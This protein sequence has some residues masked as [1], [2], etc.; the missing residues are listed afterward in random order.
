MLCIKILIFECAKFDRWCED[1]LTVE[2]WLL[3]LRM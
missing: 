2:P 3:D 1:A